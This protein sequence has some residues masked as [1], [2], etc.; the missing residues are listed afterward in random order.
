[1]HCPRRPCSAAPPRGGQ[2]KSPA[3]HYDHHC[4]MKRLPGRLP[5]LPPLPPLLPHPPLRRRAAE[6]S[7]GGGASEKVQ[8]R[9]PMCPYCVSAPPR[10]L[11]LPSQRKRCIAAVQVL[12]RH[13]H[14]KEM[15]QQQKKRKRRRRRR[16]RRKQWRMLRPRGSAV[17]GNDTTRGPP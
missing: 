17:H 4:S 1:M 7:T 3:R 16:R 13:Y 6:G 12:S 14:Q 9:R 11:I 10:G 2:E 15:L 8:L 5:P